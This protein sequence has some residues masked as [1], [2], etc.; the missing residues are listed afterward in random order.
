MA[1]EGPTTTGSI[2]AK[3]GANAEEFYAEVTSIKEKK[4][5]VETP[6]NVKIGADSS[7]A[8]A[9]LSAV[10]AAQRKLGLSTDQL[11]IAYQRLDEVQTK[12][13]ASESRLMALHLAA[14]KA[15]NARADAVRNLAAAQF[16]EAAATEVEAVATKKSTDEK[17]RSM[18]YWLKLVAVIVSLIPLMAPFGTQLF[19][20]TAA[21]GV[22][23]ATGVLAVL[24]IKDAMAKGTAEGNQFAGGIVG[25]K[26]NLDELAGTA[27][28]AM[29]GSYRTALGQINAAMPNLNSEVG[30]FS[31][32]LGQAGNF[33]LGSL[34]SGLQIAKPLLLTAGQYISQVAA[35]LLQWTKNG[36]FQSFVTYAVA[37]LPRV[38]AALGQLAT[39]FI[40]VVRA[41]AP[42]GTAVLAAI[43]GVAGAINMIPLPVLAALI[44]GGGAFFIAFKAWAALTPILEGVQAGLI[45]VGA[46]EEFALG[47]IGIVI[48]AI[49]ALTAVIGVSVIQMNTATEAQTN[50]TAAIQQDNGVIGKNT[51]LQAAKALQSAN[52]YTA[53]NTLGISTKIL[54]QATLGNSAA[55]EAYNFKLMLAKDR[56]ADSEKAMTK[57]STASATQTREYIKNRDALN[58]LID[59]QTKNQVSI[60]DAFKAYNQLAEVQGLVTIKTQDQLDVQTQLAS[61]YGSSVGVYLTAK[62]AQKQTADQLAA[63]TLQMQL[64]NDASGL[65]KQALDILNGKTL[66]VAETQTGMAAANNAITDSFKQNGKAIDG[67][68]KAAVA[69]QQAIQQS[70][71]AAQQ[72]AEAV[73]TQTGSSE[74]AR[75]ALIASKDAM[76][77]SLQSQGLLTDSVKAY[78]DQIF[79]IPASVPPT[80]IDADTAAAAAKIAALQKQLDA[81]A[82]G[83]T[84]DINAAGVVTGRNNTKSKE[85][86]RADGGTIFGPGSST[87]DSVVMPWGRGSVGEEVVKASSASAP[88]VRP[89]LKSLNYDPAGTMAR[90]GNGG[91][92]SVHNHFPTTMIVAQDGQQAYA[93]FQRQQNLQNQ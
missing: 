80:K 57:S 85:N 18:P 78:I 44:A 3:I 10:E 17:Q 5:E 21:F 53:A 88:G 14:T 2:N 79:Q 56:L 34:I 29:L 19:S 50:Y 75:Q 30:L 89:L 49:A 60:K 23:G 43:Q 37:M 12:G 72:Y 81:L 77:A 90:L 55:T 36:G 33:L 74:A 31:K 65:L 58:T 1:N 52:A 76:E 59:A 64:Q 15:E 35:D 13:G 71:Q 6:A 69:N 41:S 26:G 22:M 51:E 38:A 54:T 25:L 27:A 61:E 66:S 8:M 24:G 70:V 16:E 91:G 42:I 73:G 11:K 47:P 20:V 84:L 7:E 9:K 67:N 4:R 28:V 46:A 82:L 83:F 40:N 93:D 68:S 45:A 63:T 87:S 92:K 86:L 62:A 39:L 32:L 48:G